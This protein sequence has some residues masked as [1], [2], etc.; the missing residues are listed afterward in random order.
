[1][2][3]LSKDQENSTLIIICFISISFDLLVILLSLLPKIFEPFTRNILINLSINSILNNSLFLLGL[4]ATGTLCVSISYLKTCQLLPGVLWSSLIPQTLHSIFVQEKTLSQRPFK[5]CLL[6]SYLI[7]PIVFLLPFAT[8][9]YDHKDFNCS[10]L[11]KHTTGIVWRFLL[12]YFPSVTIILRVLVYYAQL[13]KKLKNYQEFS[14]WSFI[15][16]RGLIY[17]I[18]YLLIFIQLTVSRIIELASDSC[19]ADLL[20]FSAICCIFMIGSFNAIATLI[21]KDVIRS[22]LISLK[23]KSRRDSDS[24]FVRDILNE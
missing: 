2:V 5:Y 15:L 3:C 12:I 8:N 21:R 17:S 14:C 10:G 22:I 16:N 20:L 9:N 4:N 1:M 11:D 18:I 7:I 24:D 13:Y 6:L 19:Y 23:L